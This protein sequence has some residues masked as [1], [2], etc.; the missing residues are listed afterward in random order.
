[1]KFLQKFC[2]QNSWVK[3]KYFD[4]FIKKWQF[5][6]TKYKNIIITC[7]FCYGTYPARRP[8]RKIRRPHKDRHPKPAK[9]SYSQWPWNGTKNRDDGYDHGLGTSRLAPNWCRK[10][11]KFII[12]RTFLLIYGKNCKNLWKSK[13]MGMLKL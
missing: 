9:H 3:N 5:F 10:W 6:P 11:R 7:S 4:I 13:N 2:I 8:S 12:I 1:M